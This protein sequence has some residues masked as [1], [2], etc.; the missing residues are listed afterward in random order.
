MIVLCVYVIYVYVITLNDRRATRTP[1]DSPHS[2]N[3]IK[4]SSQGT[5]KHGM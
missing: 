5:Q 1:A 2:Y 4:W 3:Q